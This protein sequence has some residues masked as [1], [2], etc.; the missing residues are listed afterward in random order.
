M[1]APND[2]L[3]FFV[4]GAVAWLVIEFALRWFWSATHYGVST[5]EGET[6]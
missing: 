3:V 6:E 1:T 2:L 5:G 4:G